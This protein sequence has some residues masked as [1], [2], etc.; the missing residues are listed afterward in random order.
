M[1]AVYIAIF[2]L[3]VIN[4]SGIYW[5]TQVWKPVICVH[6]EPLKFD[7]ESQAL[8]VN[9]ALELS[10]RTLAAEEKAEQCS[11]FYYLLEYSLRELRGRLMHPPYDHRPSRV[12]DK[13]EKVVNQYF[14][15]GT[16]KTVCMHCNKEGFLEA[17]R[18]G[19][20]TV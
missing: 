10:K 17:V 19:T 7:S 6:N 20:A 13:C 1:L 9:I 15:D 4:V 18:R 8:L 5:F 16:G 14:I 2:S 3:A 12:C 11:T